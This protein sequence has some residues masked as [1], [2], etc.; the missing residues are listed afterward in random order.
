[1][2]VFT[3]IEV[4]CFNDVGIISK[5]RFTPMV[6]SVFGLTDCRLAHIVDHDDDKW[7]L[8]IV[9]QQNLLQLLLSQ[10]HQYVS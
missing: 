7:E 8:L 5:Y 10:R 9:C 3:E 2:L 6:I 4:W 1:M